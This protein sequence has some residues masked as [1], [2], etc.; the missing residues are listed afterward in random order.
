M[1]GCEYC[2]S[3]VMRTEGAGGSS[4]QDA[5]PIL[6]PIA[7]FLIHYNVFFG[8][9]QVPG[10]G[11]LCACRSNRGECAEIRV[12]RGCQSILTLHFGGWK[13]DLV[14]IP[15]GTC[16]DKV[17]RGM[18]RQK[19][20]NT[21]ELCKTIKRLRTEKGWSQETLAEHA[22]VSRQTVS[23][24]ETEKSYPDV[25]SL[26]ILSDIFGVSLD[27]LIKGDVEMM[28]DTVKKEDAGRFKKLQLAFVVEMFALM[29]GVT[30]LVEYGGEIGL[31]LGCLAAGALSVSIIMTFRETEQIRQDHDIQTYH[32]VLAFLNG[33][34]LDA[35][36]QAK[37]LKKR[38]SQKKLLIFVAVQA[39]ALLIFSA[40]MLIVTCIGL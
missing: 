38:G 28:K 23:N 34:T 1:N 4:L 21:M 29:F 18:D 16:Y 11:V 31:I 3:A 13:G 5:D 40:V 10:N 15:T 2:L 7:A 27:E 12:K 22:Y 9:C 33:E 19:G 20:E 24:W 26:L 32:E 14:A 17:S 39:I 35:I 36:E 30:L 8:I 6:I 37:E 25:H